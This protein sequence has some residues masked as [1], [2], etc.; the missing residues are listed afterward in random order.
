M[1]SSVAGTVKDVQVKQGDR[2]KVGQVVLTVDD[3]AAASGGEAGG[4]SGSRQGRRTAKAKPQPRA[5]RTKAAESSAAAR[6]AAKAAPPGARRGGATAGREAA[7]APTK[8]QQAEGDAGVEAEARRGRRHQPRRARRAPAAGRA[9]DGGRPRGRPPPAAPSV[10]RLAREL[11]VDIRR[12]HRQRARRPHQ[13]RRTCRRSCGSAA[14][15]RA[16]GAAAAPVPLPDFSKWGE[17]ERKPMSNIRRKTAEHLA[18]R[19]ERRSRTSRS[20]TRRTS[21]RSRSCASSYAPQAEKAGGKLTM[22]AIALKIVAAALRRFPQ[23]NAS[24]DMARSEIVYKK[25]IHI[26]VAVDTARGLLVPVIRD[27]D[28]KGIFELSAELAKVSEKARGGKLSLDEMQGGGFTI[29]NLG[30]IGGTSFTP[31]VNWPEV[32]ILGIS[33]GS[34]RA[35]VRRP[36]TFEPRLMLP[37]SLS[38]DHR[39]IDGADARALP[40]LGRARRSSSRSC[41]SL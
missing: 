24:V 10:R 35:G 25:S 30:G 34:L 15:S 36:A 19:L 28:R 2:I 12:V 16:G 1:P 13:P 20:T 27:V 32:A 31:I 17:V 7:P 22:T 6:D 38:Y 14:M 29:T 26:G 33:R 9:A 40:A 4:Q 18:P 5:R 8:R 41:S 39:V 21:P 11:G 37:L 23:F 3:G